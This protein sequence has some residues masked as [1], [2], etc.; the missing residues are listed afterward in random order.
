MLIIPKSILQMHKSN[1]KYGQREGEIQKDKVLEIKTIEGWITKYFAS[2]RKESA[3]QRVIGEA[4]KRIE[5][6]G[7]SKN[8]HK[9]Q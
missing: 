6:S 9:R 5:N 8:S 1:Q 7:N 2:L 4:N 3:E